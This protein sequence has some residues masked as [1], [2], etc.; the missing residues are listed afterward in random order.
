MAKHDGYTQTISTAEFDGTPRLALEQATGDVL[1]EGWDRPE[2]EVSVSE[3]GGMFEL[4]QDGAQVTIRNRPG[5]LKAVSF[6]GPMEEELRGVRIGLESIG[7]E[8][9]GARMERTVDKQ[10]RR[11]GRHLGSFDVG[12]WTGTDYRIR[13]PHNCDLALRTSSGDLTVKGVTGTLYIQSTSGDIKLREVDG[14]L[15]VNTSSGDVRIEGLQ[16]RMGVRTVSGDIQSHDLAL[17]EVSVTTTSGDLQLDLLRLPDKGFELKTVSGDL[18]LRLPSDSRLNFEFNTVSGDIK[19]GFPRSQV[20][21][22]SRGRREISLTLNGGG[23]TVRAQSVSGDISIVPGR[24]EA[25]P[26]GEERTAS[27][28]YT[29]DLS[30][31]SGQP[32]EPR[33]ASQAA[34]EESAEDITQP[35]GYLARQEAELEIL[36]AVKRGEL[37]PQEAMRRLSELDGK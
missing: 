15:L 12:K 22:T 5:S 37:T 3:S 24:G 21:Y 16:G 29:V 18:T 32:G 23:P 19:C 33:S 9:M 36:E 17:A 27:K 10:L 2:I 34:V 4:V 13:V 26:A 30:R 28:S 35:E 25:A 1:V 11:L 20:A 6:I 31:A 8:D 14:N 7:L